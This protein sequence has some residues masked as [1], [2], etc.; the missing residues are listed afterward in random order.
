ETGPEHPAFVRLPDTRMVA[1]LRDHD[2][3]PVK[4]L[5]I[6]NKG[7]APH[8]HEHED[9][10]S[11]VLEFAGDRFGVDLGAESYNDAN[12]ILA[13][14]C[15]LHNMLVPT[16]AD[17]R[18]KPTSPILSDVD[19]V[20]DGDETAFHIEMDATPGWDT[21]YK[22]WVRTWDSPDPATM[23]ITD[24]YE[25]AQGDGAAFYWQT[26]LPCSVE[27]QTVTIHGKRGTVTLEA[28]EGTDVSVD[29]MPT[30]FGEANNRISIVKK[31]TKGT[32]AV[33]V[34]LHWDT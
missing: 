8:S 12:H 23:T 11:F 7:E 30:I 14:Q 25:V 31:G 27:G 18:P 15:Q 21:F 16:G 28:P 20:G 10:G 22:R 13:K 9:R 1:S 5:I 34:R 17:V 6:G 4:W 32:I 2:G 33:T 26:Y 3:E 29:V 19:P 24:D